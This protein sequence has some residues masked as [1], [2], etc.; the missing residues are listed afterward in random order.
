MIMTMT[1]SQA[2][3]VW[4]LMVEA[5]VRALYFGDVASRYTKR[6][7]II[8]GLSLLLSSG[9]AATIVA[10]APSAVPLVMAAVTAFLSAYQIS[11]GLDRKIAALVKL[12]GA[13]HSLQSSYE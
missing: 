1:E 4:E 5:E 6:R 12:H 2:N 10:Q 9:A 3:R 8:T 11:V 13:W 7:Q